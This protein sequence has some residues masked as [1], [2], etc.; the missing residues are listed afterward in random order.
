LELIEEKV[1]Y[2]DFN[3]EIKDFPEKTQTLCFDYSPLLSTI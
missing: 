1:S 2:I 3:T